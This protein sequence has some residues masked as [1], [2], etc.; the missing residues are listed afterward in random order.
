M[1]GKLGERRHTADQGVASDCAGLFVMDEKHQG[2]SYLLSS[3]G[4]VLNGV[5]SDTRVQ[6]IIRL[7]NYR[8]GFWRRVLETRIV[9]CDQFFIPLG[10]RAPM[11]QSKNC[12]KSQWVLDSRPSFHSEMSLS[13]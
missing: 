4:F 9:Q 5:T 13:S 1:G 8:R 12:H 3:H 11:K 6:D 2:D 10:Y 7:T